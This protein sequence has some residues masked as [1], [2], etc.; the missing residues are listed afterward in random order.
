MNRHRSDVGFLGMP[1]SS[2]A[3]KTIG[4]ENLVGIGPCC[5]KTMISFGH[6]KPHFVPKIPTTF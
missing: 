4:F 1:L 2:E 6:P 3:K 5:P